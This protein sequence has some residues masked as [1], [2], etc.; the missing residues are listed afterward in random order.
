MGV[1]LKDGAAVG[2]A[3]PKHGEASTVR[4]ASFPHVSLSAVPPDGRAR[5]AV[6]VLT[7]EDFEL[8]RKT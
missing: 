3:A 2:D 8:H 1:P 7:V 5:A 4:N 6:A